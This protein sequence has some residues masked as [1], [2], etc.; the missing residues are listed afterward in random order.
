MQSQ[1]VRRHGAV[2][3]APPDLVD[4]VENLEELPTDRPVGLES[5]SGEFRRDGVRLAM[6]RELNEVGFEAFELLSLDPHLHSSPF[7]ADR[8]PEP[9]FS[10]TAG[11]I[12]AT[13]SPVAVAPAQKSMQSQRVATTAV[14][15]FKNLDEQLGATSTRVLSI[16]SPPP[17][18]VNPPGFIPFDRVASF[19]RTGDS[20]RNPP[21]VRDSDRLLTR[22]PFR[23][24]IV[25]GTIR[26][27]ANEPRLPCRGH[28]EASA[29]FYLSH[30]PSLLALK[31]SKLSLRAPDT[32]P[33]PADLPA[34]VNVVVNTVTSVQG[35]YP[36][37]I[38]RCTSGLPP[39]R[40]FHACA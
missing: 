37:R 17:K 10:A 22:Q 39:R 33:A 20:G 21:P 11:A 1:C 6:G 15:V 5:E 29:S 27:H 12:A 31:H 14:A 2:P 13:G 36:F 9:P 23:R 16:V 8:V 34:L 28:R 18:G 7:V 40:S 19:P 3:R 25:P 35:C 30:T 24:R 32:T 26:Q 4:G 38:A